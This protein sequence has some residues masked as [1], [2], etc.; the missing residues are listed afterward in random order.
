MGH[1]IMSLVSE[2]TPGRLTLITGATGSGKTSACLQWCEQMLS[3]REPVL[4]LDSDHTLSLVRLAHYAGFADYFWGFRPSSP[5]QG[6]HLAL[7]YFRQRKGGVVVLDSIDGL[8]PEAGDQQAWVKR[9]LPRLIGALYVSKS[10]L[11]CT[12][13][14]EPSARRSRLAMYAYQ[15][16]NLGWGYESY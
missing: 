5:E 6:Y 7:A 15:H 12:S 11:L 14:A 10:R 8:I 1:A 16:I 2:L 9:F 4:W 13:H 3:R